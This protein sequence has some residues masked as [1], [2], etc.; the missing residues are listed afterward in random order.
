M[1]LNPGGTFAYNVWN[2]WREEILPDG[3]ELIYDSDMIF[4]RLL[5]LPDD[6]TLELA[7]LGSILFVN[8]NVV[9]YNQGGD[10]ILVG[11]GRDIDRVG[12][13]EGI[14]EYLWTSDLQGT[15]GNGKIV[16]IPVTNLTLGAHT[17]TFKVK[18]NDG[19]WSTDQTVKVIVLENLYQV[20]LPLIQ[21]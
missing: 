15:L 4:R 16:K 11:T 14:V 18:D 19:R 2:Q 12:E 5:Y 17:I 1:V 13:G 7:P 6:S 10:L 3:E 8:A 21:H 20:R 9:A